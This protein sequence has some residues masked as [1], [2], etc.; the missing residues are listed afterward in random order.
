MKLQIAGRI[1]PG[2]EMLVAHGG[3][4]ERRFVALFGRGG[5]L[6]GAVAMNRVRQ[7]MAYRRLLRDGASWEQALAQ[8]AE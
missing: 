8:A 6:T 2:D 4:E 5:R 1:R 3:L 7:C